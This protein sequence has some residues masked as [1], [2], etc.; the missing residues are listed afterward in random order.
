MLQNGYIKLHRNIFKWELWQDQKAFRLF[1]TLLLMANVSDAE[2]E[3][4]LVQRGQVVTSL[5]RLSEISG[6]TPKQ[7]RSSLAKLERAKSVANLSSPKN[8]IITI[9]NYEKFQ[10]GAKSAA[11]QNEGKEN[12]KE[13]GKEN[14]KEE[15]KAKTTKKTCND[16]VS[17]VFHS[18][19][20]KE[21]GKENGKEEGK[22]KGN[23]IRRNIKKGVPKG[24]PRKEESL[25]W[26]A[27]AWQPTVPEGMTEEKY[28]EL[29]R[30]LSK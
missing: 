22:E 15:G 18:K 10:N 23:N 2:F 20:G 13:K 7:V 21:K 9:K 14:G 6:L 29:V 5:K 1:V 24:T 4:E 28:L 8:R 12:G 11:N 16:C 19:E 17:D 25:P 30:E 27:S 26:S 3:G